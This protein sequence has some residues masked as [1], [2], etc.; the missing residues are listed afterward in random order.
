MLLLFGFITLINTLIQERGSTTTYERTSSGEKSIVD[1]HCYHITT[2][3][4]VDIKE[5][6]EQLS[7][8][9]WLPELHKRH[10][11]RFNA[12]SSSCTTT[13]LSKLLTSG[14]TAVKNHFIKYCETI[15]ERDGINLFWSIKNSNEVLNKFKSKDFKAS[16]LSTY[17]FSTLYTPLPHHLIEDK[18]TD[19]IERKFSREK[20]KH[21][22]WLVTKKVHFSLLMCSKL[23][24]F[25]SPVKKV[26]ESFV[27]LL[28]NIFTGF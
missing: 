24:L 6:P 17:D 8:L 21:F 15:Y 25:Y 13:V 11:A 27:Y 7:T 2:K 19:L 22:F 28:D 26:F 5:N 16:E 4:A 12:N 14:L 10:Q 23:I 18:L 3:F 1:N 9:Y 20:K